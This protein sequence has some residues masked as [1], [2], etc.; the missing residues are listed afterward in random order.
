MSLGALLV[1][2]IAFT[3]YNKSVLNQVPFGWVAFITTLWIGWE[4]NL[5]IPQIQTYCMIVNLN[6]KERLSTPMKPINLIGPLHTQCTTWQ[7]KLGQLGLISFAAQ[8]KIKVVMSDYDFACFLEEVNIELLL[9]ERSLDV[10][11]LWVRFAAHSAGSFL[12]SR[13][14]HHLRQGRSFLQNKAGSFNISDSCCFNNWQQS[15]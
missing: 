7:T 4:I 9:I 11:T 6:Y 3:N 12:H 10:Q 8:K 15:F 13:E 2:V 1:T 5:P 14:L